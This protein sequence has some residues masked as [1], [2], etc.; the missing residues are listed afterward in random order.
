VSEVGLGL[1]GDVEPARYGEL[2]ALA[3]RAGFDVLSV[4]GDLLFQPPLPALLLAARATRRIRLGPAC[5]NPYTTHPVEIAGQIAVLDHLSRGRAYLGL[6]RGA[7][8]DAVGVAQA[9]PVDAVRDAAQI[10]RRL[11]AG[12]AVG[13]RGR[14]FRLAPG[15]RLEQRVLRPSVPLLVGAWGPRMCALAGEIADELKVGGSA[16]PAMVA[17]ARSRLGRASTGIV[18]GS[19]TVID[20]DG[21][22]ARRLARAEVARYV[23]VVGPLDP[24]APIDPELARRLHDLVAIR[25][26]DEAGRLLS[27]ELLDRF[28]LAGTPD[29]VAARAAAL[30]AAGARRVDF[31]PPLSPHGIA[32]GID[33]LGSKVIPQLRG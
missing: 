22:A 27:D 11:L 19:V 6:A 29:Q 28:S 2:G 33:L 21:A 30:F 8:L 1:R 20:D 7:W 18:M 14:V 32:A 24:T 12:D 9:R 10:V 17:V 16:S 4:F 31:G 25:A 5:L 23:D 13:Y 3:E 15:A 26:H